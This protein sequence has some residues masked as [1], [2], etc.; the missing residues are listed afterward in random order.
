MSRREQEVR[1][2]VEAVRRSKLLAELELPDEFFPA[3]LSVAVVDA[4]FRPALQDRAQEIV[5]RYCSRFG[6]RTIRAERWGPPPPAEQEALSDLIRHY[7]VLGTE[8]MMDDVFQ[9][10]ECSLGTKIPK[11]E[12]VV[13]AAR[14]LHD[15]GLDIIQN[16]S[17]RLPGEI[18]D[19]LRP[20]YGIDGRTIR[21]LSTYLGGKD[22]VRG[23]FYLRKYVACALGCKMVTATRAESLVRK[24]AHELILSPRYLAHAIWR[25]ASSIGQTAQPFHSFLKN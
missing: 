1:Q 22:F 2:L 18:E 23:D 25:F 4:V 19:T 10:R 13:G 9:S 15:I 16:V 3:H 17:A 20:L 5:D 8:V 12:I 14:A 24:A 11:A 7:D 6:I 21:L